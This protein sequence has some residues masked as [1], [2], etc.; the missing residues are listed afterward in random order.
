MSDE[1]DRNQNHNGATDNNANECISP[2]NISTKDTTVNEDAVE[3]PKDKRSNHSEETAV[4]R[5]RARTAYFIFADD[6]RREFK[7]NNISHK[8]VANQAREIGQL[9]SNLPA[10]EKETYKLLAAKEKELTPIIPT[11]PSKTNGLTI[12][13]NSIRKLIK[14]DPE[15]KSISKE[16]ISMVTKS[17]EL[18]TTKLASDVC[19]VA[20][21]Q[22]RR[23]LYVDDVVEI[24]SSKE[25]FLFLKEDIK[26]LKFQKKKKDVGNVK[27]TGAIHQYF[28]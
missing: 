19:N 5:K 13:N 12:P 16:A 14:L 2:Q 21:I 27:M 1:D 17:C 6:K 4:P 22:N 20:K 18:F 28:T 7:E 8:S 9:W 26:D 24:C 11:T 15:L 3:S 10:E 23:T 25:Q